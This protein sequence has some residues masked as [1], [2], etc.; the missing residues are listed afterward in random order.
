[1]RGGLE[2]TETDQHVEIRPSSYFT[3]CQ[4][5]QDWSLHCDVV[6]ID[7]YGVLTGTAGFGRARP[8]CMLGF[9]SCLQPVRSWLLG[10]HGSCE[11]GRS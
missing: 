2:R 3:L 11:D 10:R 5:V 4:V 7:G 8:A 6:L 9:L 1:M